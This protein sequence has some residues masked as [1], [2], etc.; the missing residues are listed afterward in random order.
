V[1]ER[2]GAATEKQNL[3]F[4]LAG[5]RQQTVHGGDIW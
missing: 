5:N 2:S 1:D 4:V 3:P